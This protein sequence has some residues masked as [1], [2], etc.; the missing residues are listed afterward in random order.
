MTQN[1]I[2]AN[3][4]VDNTALQAL[5]KELSGKVVNQLPGGET[6]T[7]AEILVVLGKAGSNQ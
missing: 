2:F 3:K 7:K 6:A 5:A 1:Q 4:T